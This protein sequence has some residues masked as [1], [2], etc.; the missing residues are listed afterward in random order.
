MRSSRTNVRKINLPAVIRLP[1]PEETRFG[2][3]A[4]EV[5]RAILPV[6]SGAQCMRNAYL[7]PAGSTEF[8]AVSPR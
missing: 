5:S 4:S 1:F 8:W 6:L 3:T 2:G 7:P